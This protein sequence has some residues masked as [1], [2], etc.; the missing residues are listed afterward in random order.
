MMMIMITIV[1]TV[2]TEQIQNKFH[3]IWNCTNHT[4]YY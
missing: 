3:C 2:T 1:I 4:Y